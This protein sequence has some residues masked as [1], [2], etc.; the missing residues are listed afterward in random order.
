MA[1]EPENPRPLATM[2]EQALA[3]V[4]LDGSKSL[5]TIV[6][7]LGLRELVSWLNQHTPKEVEDQAKLVR[8]VYPSLKHMQD[9]LIHLRVAGK[10]LVPQDIENDLLWVDINGDT[11][12]HKASSNATKGDV[13]IATLNR[14][15]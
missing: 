2:R 13:F 8:I 11:A 4:E 9:D 5:L 3:P 14:L 12:L 6:R 15:S 10:T 7:E 1:V